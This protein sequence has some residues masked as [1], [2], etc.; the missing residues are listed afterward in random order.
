M[1]INNTHSRC[2]S[3]HKLEGVHDHLMS[4]RF[5]TLIMNKIFIQ[6]LKNMEEWLRLWFGLASHLILTT[7]FISRE[8]YTSWIK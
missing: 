3:Q 6:A 4:M 5:F 8:K 1:A 7:S 2:N